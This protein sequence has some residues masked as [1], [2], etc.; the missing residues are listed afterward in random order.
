MNRGDEGVATNSTFDCRD[1]ER[2]G[3]HHEHAEERGIRPVRA[4]LYAVE[5]QEPSGRLLG[6]VRKRG[7][8]RH[9]EGALPKWTHRASH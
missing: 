4:T 9:L 8:F 5:T 7:G 2:K 6:C 3:S 1:V